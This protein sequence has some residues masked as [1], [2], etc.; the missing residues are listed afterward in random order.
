M[1][2]G[3]IFPKKLVIFEIFTSFETV[4]L[5]FQHFYDVFTDFWFFFQ[6]QSFLRYLHH[7][8]VYFNDFFEKLLRTMF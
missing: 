2:I 5:I 8:E 7:F 1:K 4:L 6:I 3:R